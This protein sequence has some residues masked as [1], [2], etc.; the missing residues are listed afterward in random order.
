M[1]VP[2]EVIA[3]TEALDDDEVRLAVKSLA[4]KVL[5]DVTRLFDYG[6]P[7]IKLSVARTLLP[8]LVKSLAT[9]DE[10]AEVRL[11]KE[12]LDTMMQEMR[13]S[14]VT[15]VKVLPGTPIPIDKPH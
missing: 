11:M 13:D 1:S 3:V 7:A 4:L 14:R 8:S 2:R 6:D 12:Q 15:R 5:S 10:N 9:K